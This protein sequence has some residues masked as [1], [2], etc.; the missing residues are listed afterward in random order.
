MKQ[1]RLKWGRSYHIYNRGNNRG[2]IFFEV[3]N[4]AYFL[5]MYKKYMANLA[6]L[7]AY[8]L[9]PNHFHLLL[10]IND[11]GEHI[12]TGEGM[13][14]TRF[15]T[16][17]GTYVKAIN[18]RYKRTGSLFEGRY[19]KVEIGS[20]NQ[21]FITLVYI[22]QNPQKHGYVESFQSWRYSSYTNYAENNP[23]DL[24]SSVLFRDP[25]TYDSIMELHEINTQDAGS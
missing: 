9:L 5:K 4:Y 18:A 17:L 2:Q 15:G 16:F 3:E 10:R 6:V 13:V 23:G 8:C 1:S 25:S 24:I 19:Q 20:E 21:F 12:K 11:E 7:Y 22:H 14:S